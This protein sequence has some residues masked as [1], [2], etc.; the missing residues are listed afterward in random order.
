MLFSPQHPHGGHSITSRSVFSAAGRSVRIFVGVWILIPL[1]AV[2]QEPVPRIGI[3]LPT[4]IQ[5][6]SL[7]ARGRV[8]KSETRWVGRTIVT[9]HELNVSETIKGARS[10]KVTVGVPGGSIGNVQTIWPGS[11][12]I[13]AGDEL[14]FFGVPTPDNE[15]YSAVGLFDGLVKV[16][17]QPNGRQLYVQPR[18]QPE[19]VET[20]L[21]EVRFIHS[22]PR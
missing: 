12:N 8:E 6:A 20:F 19:P 11:P 2:A 10:G 3:D 9:F 13:V 4:V 15:S 1:M 21:N 7:I 17:E 16:H 14:V 5:K 18:G 22:F